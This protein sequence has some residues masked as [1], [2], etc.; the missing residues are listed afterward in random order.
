MFLYLHIMT[1][2]LIKAILHLIVPIMLQGLIL[3]AVKP[4]TSL[5]KIIP[6]K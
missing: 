1:R 4:D 3:L 6:L 2:N 5:T